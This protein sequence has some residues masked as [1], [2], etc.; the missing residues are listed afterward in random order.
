MVW[1]AIR[2]VRLRWKTMNSGGRLTKNPTVQK[3]ARQQ[4]FSL[5][6][7]AKSLDAMCIAHTSGAIDGWLPY[8]LRSGT[9]QAGMR[10]ANAD[11]ATDGW[12]LSSAEELGD[13]SRGHCCFPCGTAPGNW[14]D[15]SGRAV[16]ASA[17]KRLRSCAVGCICRFQ[18][19]RV[20][21]VAYLTTACP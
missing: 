7:V 17:R 13:S 12:L 16:E 4:A 18:R 5:L 20:R 9:S 19:S 21:R 11:G 3:S 10:I 8:T 6:Q 1:N 2:E 14:R 15:E